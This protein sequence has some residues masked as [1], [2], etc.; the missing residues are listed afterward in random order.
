MSTESIVV[1][2]GAITLLATVA[3]NPELESSRQPLEFRLV[4]GLIIMAT[5]L[6]PV[7]RAILANPI[8][9]S[10]RSMWAIVP[11]T[12]LVPLSITAL[13]TFALTIRRQRKFLQLLALTALLFTATSIASFAY[14]HGLGFDPFI[15][16]ASVA[17]IAEFGTITPK[18]LYYIGQYAL[19]LT[20]HLGFLQP[21][22]WVDKLLVPL[23]ASLLLPATAYVGLT[24]LT[25]RYAMFGALS[26]ILAP[27]ALFTITTPQSLGYLLFAGTLFLLMPN[28]VAKRLT[29]ISHW[30]FLPLTFATLLIHPI[31]GIASALAFSLILATTFLTGMWRKIILFIIASTGVFLYPLSFF[32]QSLFA[33]LPISLQAPNI[34][35]MFERIPS[36]LTTYHL[37][38]DLVTFPAIIAPAV[39]FIAYLIALVQLRSHNAHHRLVALAIIPII[40]FLNYLLMQFVSF[41]FLIDYERANYTNRLLTLALLSTL[42]FVAITLMKLKERIGNAP[43]LYSSTILT[44]LAILFTSSTYSAYPHHDAY[45]YSRDYNT[46][47]ADIEAVTTIEAHANG[48]PYAVLANQMVSSASLHV[49]GFAHYYRDNTA[50]YYPIPTSEPL[51]QFYLDMVEDKPTRALAL[52][53][54]DYMGVDRLYL[55]VNDYWWNARN[56]IEE[57]RSV[58]ETELLTENPHISIFVFS[59]PAD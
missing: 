1:L 42:P 32:L 55:V 25:R 40:L 49:Y 26:I 44:V 11:P 59:R 43:P 15:H 7:W 24:A 2:L 37:P 20:A 45:H 28:I 34:G 47:S 30:L 27:I 53:A 18:P 22:L 4:A 3:Q 35:L 57:A 19:E 9:E 10:T 14:T 36:F 31:A 56:T 33:G 38:T 54:M 50:F 23:L 48:T 5:L 6:V 58:A 13:I 46:S 41:D 52:S 29:P 21:I 39:A 8:T 16:R 12:L 17:H 51:Y